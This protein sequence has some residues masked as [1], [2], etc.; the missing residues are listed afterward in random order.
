MTH[1]A[2]TTPRPRPR[3][4]IER[5]LPL[6]IS[7]LLAAVLGGALLLTHA[8][9]TRAARQTAIERIRSAAGQLAGLGAASI[10]RIKQTV[11]TA[12]RD[13]TLHRAARPGATPRD[14]AAAHALLER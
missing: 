8:T 3:Q 12:A 6:L 11:G 1:S 10:V 7:A 9:L 5:T 14:L 4:S 13:S 2:P